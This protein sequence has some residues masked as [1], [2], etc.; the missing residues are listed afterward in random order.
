MFFTALIGTYMILRNGTP[1]A[2][3]GFRWPSPHDVHLSE[4][5][6]AING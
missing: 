1:A 2:A 6:G 3:P 4:T 5:I